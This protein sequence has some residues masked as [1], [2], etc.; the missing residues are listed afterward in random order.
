MAF[1]PD[2]RF[3][4]VLCNAVLEHDRFFW[5]TLAE[6]RRVTRAGGLVVIGTPGF[7][8][9]PYENKASPSARQ[10]IALFPASGRM[11]LTALDPH[12]CRPQFPRLTIIVS[13][14]RRFGRFSSKE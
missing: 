7:R 8:D 4:V 6:I 14:N 12:A 5:E 9:L 11:A 2:Q 1:F 3:D 13:A 10:T